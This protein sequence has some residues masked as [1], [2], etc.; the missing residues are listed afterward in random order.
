[1]VN[2]TR[3]LLSAD[4]P[5]PSFALEV[6]LGYIPVLPGA[7]SSMLTNLFSLEDKNGFLLELERGRTE[8][9]F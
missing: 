7:I 9:R 8:G 5:T 3:L 2:Q 1:M 4:V 6:H